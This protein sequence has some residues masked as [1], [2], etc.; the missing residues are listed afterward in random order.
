MTSQNIINMYNGVA[1]GGEAAEGQVIE[2]EGEEEGQQNETINT[3]IEATEMVDLSGSDNLIF[4]E[5]IINKIY[6]P[7]VNDY[8]LQGTNRFDVINQKSSFNIIFEKDKI[9]YGFGMNN[10]TS[11]NKVF[12]DNDYDSIGYTNYSKKL[13]LVIDENGKIYFGTLKFETE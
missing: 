6:D 10:S 7:S 3:A 1:E 11:G 9:S 8:N 4:K 2:V 13:L 5:V 12:L